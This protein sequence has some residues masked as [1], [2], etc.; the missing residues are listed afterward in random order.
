[1]IFKLMVKKYSFFTGKFDFPNQPMYFCEYFCFFPNEL[2]AIWIYAKDFHLDI[3]IS[4]SNQFMELSLEQCLRL[5]RIWQDFR[6]SSSSSSFSSGVIGVCF[7]LPQ[8]TQPSRTSLA[9]PWTVEKKL[10]TL[11]IKLM[12]DPPTRIPLRRLQWRG[13]ARRRPGWAARRCGSRK[14]PL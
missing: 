13:P 11:W 5:V 2:A 10:S 8:K 4:K 6:L 12:V 7:L 1:M 9:P 3:S 14:R